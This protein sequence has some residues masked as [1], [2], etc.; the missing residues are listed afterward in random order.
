MNLDLD[1]IFRGGRVPDWLR[2]FA[3]DPD[4]ALH[5]LVLGRADLG[6][7]TVADP[8]DLLLGWLRALANRSDFTAQVD[9]SLSSWI[10]RNWGLIELPGGAD[11]ATLTSAAWVRVGEL[12]AAAPTLTAAGDV[13]AQRV[14]ADRRYLNS[15][16]EGRSRDPQAAA[17]LALATHQRDRSLLT[18]WWQL[19]ELPPDQPWYRGRCGIAGLR[20]LPGKSAARAGGFP[21]EVAEGL[22]RF[23]LALWR[24]RDEGWL[25]P[26]LAAEEFLDVVRLCLSAYPFPDRWM[27][28]WRHVLRRDYRRG[29]LGA[30]IQR[31]LPRVADEQS[32]KG[33]NRPNW[34]NYDPAWSDRRNAIAEKLRRGSEGAVAEAERLLAE[35]HRYFERSGDSYGLAYSATTLSAAVRRRQPTKA[36]QWAR[37]A[38]EVEPWNS[39]AWNNEGQALLVRGDGIAAMEVYRETKARFPDNVVARNGLAEVLKAQHRF[40]DA[41]AEYREAKALFPDNVFAR[42]GLAEVLKAQDRFV[43]AEAEYHEAKARFPDNVIARNG[44]AEV[45]KA[46]DRLVD[47]EAEYRELKVA[48]PMSFAP[49]NSLAWILKAQ[50]R[51]DE[52]VVEYKEAIGLFPENVHLHMALGAA[53]V[54]SNRPAEAE[55]YYRQAQDQFPDETFAYA[56]LAD[57]LVGQDRLSEA[58]HE[59]RE[60][61]RRASDSFAVWVGLARVLTLQGRADEAEAEYL[62]MEDR[63]PNKRAPRGNWDEVPDSVPE[64][65]DSPVITDEG[66]IAPLEAEFPS[67]FPAS[68]IEAPSAHVEAPAKTSAEPGE[69]PWLNRQE[70][71]M[72]AGDAFLIRGWA[73]ATGTYQQFPAKKIILKNNNLFFF[74]QE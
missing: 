25:S 36:L 28:F 47:A 31:L 45:L 9:Q 61:R 57:I 41:E 63:F 22:N 27:S 46:Q 72:V 24:L 53:L 73:R 74:L 18:T 62:A 66:D 48:Y 29:D 10:L 42:N 43:D 50:G 64:D 49:R 55:A 71:D 65:T 15:L 14:L 3:A 40:A 1:R 32:S 58:E 23:G 68:V 17:W 54:E 6:H 33:S 37:L 70:I 20:A 5:D 44:L 69:E 7:L 51:W 34:T 16:C 35:Q 30:W 39:Y 67:T 8:V 4:T 56:K 2:S 60:A 59:Y 11:S 12:L 13:L 19:C 21:K 26:D 52:A 38:K